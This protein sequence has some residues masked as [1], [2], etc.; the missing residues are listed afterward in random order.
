MKADLLGPL[1]VPV[2][3]VHKQTKKRAKFTYRYDVTPQG[4]NK[5]IPYIYGRLMVFDKKN[6]KQRNVGNTKTPRNLPESETLRAF[7]EWIVADLDAMGYE[8][9]GIVK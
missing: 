2:E 3:A 4:A 7:W 6:N 5:S 9:N 1:S 8:F